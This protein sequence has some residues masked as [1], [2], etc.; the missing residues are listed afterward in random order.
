MKRSLTF[1]TISAC[2]VLAR[3]ASASSVPL[4]TNTANFQLTGGGG[5]EQATLGGATVEIFGDD[6]ENSIAIHH[7]YSANVT[8]L[9]ANADLDETR[10]GG[11]ASNAWTT[12][13]LSG[14]LKVTTPYRNFFNS[15]AGSAALARYEM[16]AYLVSQYSL[17]SG[18]N[19]ANKQIQEAIWTLLDP[20]QEGAA[21]NPANVN[22]TG[23]L[24][25]AA[26][27]YN[28][29]HKPGNL[30]A[31]NSMLKDFEIVSPATMKF[32]KGLGTG[33][34]EEQIV[35][36][37]TTKPAVLGAQ[38]LVATPEPRNASILIGLIAMAG[39]LANR[40]RKERASAMA[41]G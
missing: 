22:P 5:G 32:R 1:I 39:C 33:G 4:H 36:A 27:W 3:G 16:A 24:E 11:V 13:G 10:F 15:G 28:T 30:S 38:N 31:L 25:S 35:M 7:D 12:I 19:T 40:F 23:Y 2:L 34:F 9:S 29:M 14:R 18:N 26:D 17:G 6:F 20:A 21:S 8:A 41:A 37:P